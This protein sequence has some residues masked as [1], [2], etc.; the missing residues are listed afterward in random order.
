[1]STGPSKE[2]Q[3]RIIRM[4]EETETI[5]QEMRRKE[6]RG[7]PYNFEEVDAVL[8]LADHYT[9]PERTTSGLEEQQRWFMKLR[10]KREREKE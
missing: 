4:R 5:L 10:E 3:R 7:K 9:G 8:S 2:E 6:L 1:M